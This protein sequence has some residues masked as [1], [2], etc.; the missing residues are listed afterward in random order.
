MKIQNFNNVNC[1]FVFCFLRY[2]NLENVYLIFLDALLLF[3]TPVK[4]SQRPQTK[5]QTYLLKPEK[6]PMLILELWISVFT[7]PMLHRINV[8]AQTSQTEG[9]QY[10]R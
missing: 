4:R 8:N 2:V 7:S 1:D 9:N 5:T 10:L 6:Q 3:L